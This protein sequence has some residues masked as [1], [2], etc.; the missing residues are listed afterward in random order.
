MDNFVAVRRETQSRRC[1]NPSSCQGKRRRSHVFQGSR[2]VDIDSILKRKSMPMSRS[3]LRK[4][5]PKTEALWSFNSPPPPL[6]L[7]FVFCGLGFAHA[8]LLK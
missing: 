3:R 7:Q 4:E 8:L 2:G 1:G 5:P 6:P